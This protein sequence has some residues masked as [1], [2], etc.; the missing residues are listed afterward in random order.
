VYQIPFDDKWTE[1]SW[2]S[3]RI[4][5]APR[6]CSVDLRDGNQAL[7]NPMNHER[8]YRLFKHLLE[9]GFKEIEVGFPS[10]S[11]TEFDFC[12]YI[13]EN[14]EIPEDV[15]IQVMC[16]CKEN[17]LK[18]TVEAVKGAKKVI[19]HIYNST[20]ELQ[21]RVVFDKGREGIKQLA[22]EGVRML[23]NMADEELVAHGTHVRYL[24]T[25]ESFT[26]TE[27]DFAVDVC[28]AV[29]KIVAPK[30]EDKIMINLCATVE[31]ASPNVYADQVEWMC[32]HFDDRRKVTLSSHPHN[33]RGCGVPAAE[34][35]QLA[36]ADRVEGCLFGNGERTGN[37]CLVTLAS[38]LFFQGIDPELDLRDIPKCIEI[39]E[40]ANELPV[41]ECNRGRVN[42]M[43]VFNNSN[44]GYSSSSEPS[45][46]NCSSKHLPVT[47][48]SS[49]TL[50][51]YGTGSS[52]SGS[53]PA[54]S[55]DGNY[56]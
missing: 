52:P 20:S 6:W 34:F 45:P 27:L 4:K 7:P 53:S 43:K 1:R 19:F 51:G 32:A 16:S 5:Q 40:F 26:G 54:S 21:R 3:K 24:Y 56:A 38:N 44:D 11:Q 9:I 17:L 25:P 35:A 42:L 36:G 30:P 50:T 23:K 15:H 49:T 29:T 46:A 37:V 13:I 31:M 41:P 2:P 8:K 48:S 33:D 18:R 47:A 10:A 22:L 55:T 12:R 14:N 28:N 39:V